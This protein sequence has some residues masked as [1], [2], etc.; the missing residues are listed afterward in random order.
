M[1]RLARLR[2]VSP[3]HASEINESFR[4]EMITAMSTIS[5]RCKTNGFPLYQ[6]QSFRCG[7]SVTKQKSFV[8]TLHVR[9]LQNK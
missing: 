7:G 9:Y 1:L 3:Q 8:S 2:R 4:L 6:V 5:L